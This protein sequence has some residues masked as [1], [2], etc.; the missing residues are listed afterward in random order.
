MKLRFTGLLFAILLLT[1]TQVAAQRFLM[2]LV[3]T[4]NQMGKGML[5]IYERYNRVRISGYIQPQFQVISKEGAETYNG[6]NFSA[7][8]N[9]RFMLRRGRLTCRL[10]TFE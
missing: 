2:D 8:S 1:T 9:N 6:G 5:S 4:T 3:D 10:C 7:L